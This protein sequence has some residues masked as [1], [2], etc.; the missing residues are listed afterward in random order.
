MNQAVQGVRALHIQGWAAFRV[1]IWHS[2]LGKELQLGKLQGPA[3]LWKDFHILEGLKNALIQKAET[4]AIQERYRQD[5]LN[6]WLNTAH[7][8]QKGRWRENL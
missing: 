5:K 7:M 2:G 4:D 8:A 1:S 6:C 3:V